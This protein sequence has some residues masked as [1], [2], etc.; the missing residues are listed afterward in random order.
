MKKKLALIAF[1]IVCTIGLTLSIASFTL[2]QNGSNATAETGNNLAEIYNS[3]LTQVQHIIE[4]SNLENTEDAITH[5]HIVQIVDTKDAVDSANKKLAD[6]IKDYINNDNDTAEATGIFRTDIIGSD[7]KNKHIDIETYVGSDSKLADAI[8]NADLVYIACNSTYTSS[9]DIKSDTVASDA[10]DALETYALSEFKPVI[11]DSDVVGVTNRDVEL[12]NSHSTKIYDYLKRISGL[13]ETVKGIGVVSVKDKDVQWD[14]FFDETSQQSIYVSFNNMGTNVANTYDYSNKNKAH[15]VLEIVPDEASKKGG[16]TDF[17]QQIDSGVFNKAFADDSTVT[18]DNIDYVSMTVTEFNAE[19]E[20]RIS[21]DGKTAKNSFFDY[22][23]IYIS[24]ESTDKL[25]FYEDDAAKGITKNDFSDNAI[26]A[27]KGFVNKKNTDREDLTEDEKKQIKESDYID[28]LIIDGRFFNIYSYAN[29]TS[30]NGKV[31]TSTKMY[32]FA[33]KLISKDATSTLLKNV[34]I[35]S[36]GYFGSMTEEKTEA[37]TS[38]INRSTYRTYA[39]GSN[40]ANFKVLEIQP[41]YSVDDTKWYNERRDDLTGTLANSSY[42]E[43]Y[44]ATNAMYADNVDGVTQSSPFYRFTMTQAKI[45]AATGLNMNQIVVT[46]MSANALC[47]TSPN[48]LEEYDLIYIGGNYSSIKDKK[49]WNSYK[50]LTN[51]KNASNGAAYSFISYHPDDIN[52]FYFGSTAGSN[53][54]SSLTYNAYVYPCYTHTGDFVDIT[55]QRNAFANRVGDRYENSGSRLNGNDITAKVYARLYEYISAGMPVVCD[56]EVIDSDYLIGGASAN[57]DLVADSDYKIDLETGGTLNRY[58]L[59]AATD[60]NA[61]LTFKNKSGSMQTITYKATNYSSSTMTARRESSIDPESYIYQ[62]MYQIAENKDSGIY[63]AKN[64]LVGFDSS[65]TTTTNNMYLQGVTSDIED[66]IPE[67]IETSTSDKKQNLVATLATEKY[68][69]YDMVTIF[70]NTRNGSK[71]DTDYA[72][73]GAGI[74]LKHFLNLYASSRPVINLIKAPENYDSTRDLDKK[75]RIVNP[76]SPTYTLSIN[77]E[78]GKTYE[79]RL[80]YDFDGDGKYSD[81]ATEGRLEG[82]EYEDEIVAKFDYTVGTTGNVILDENSSYVEKESFIIDSDFVGVMPYKLVVID[83]ENGKKT[84]IVGYPKYYSDTEE[85]K[86]TI[87]LLQIVPGYESGSMGNITQKVTTLCAHE[88]TLGNGSNLGSADNGKHEFGIVSA[89]DSTD[90]LAS[91]LFDEYNVDL[92]IMTT[93]QFSEMAELFILDYCQN[94]ET[95]KG[96]DKLSEDQIAD[97]EQFMADYYDSGSKKMKS[98]WTSLVDWNN[99]TIVDF[100]AL[101][102]SD[103]IFNSW[104]TNGDTEQEIK[105]NTKSYNGKTQTFS[106]GYYD[107]VVIGFSKEMGHN[108]FERA[109]I[110]NIGCQFLRAYIEDYGS[111]LLGTDTTSFEGF[112]DTSTM[113]WSRNINQYLRQAFGMD[114]F[115]FT[116]NGTKSTG[117]NTSDFYNYI[118]DGGTFDGGG[119]AYIYTPY[120]TVDYSDSTGQVYPGE[121]FT[122]NSYNGTYEQDTSKVN[123]M[124]GAG[125]TDAAD[126]ALS[127]SDTIFKGVTVANIGQGTAMLPTTSVARNNTGLITNYPFN[128]SAYP[129]ISKTNAQSYALDTEDDDMQIWYTLAGASDSDNSSLYAADPLNGRSYYYIYS[130]RNVTYTGAGYTAIAETAGN[131]EERKLIINAILSHVKIHRSGPKVVFSSYTGSEENDSV[132]TAATATQDAVLE[133]SAQTKNKCNFDFTVTTAKDRTFKDVTMFIDSNEDGIYNE[134]DGDILI[135]SYTESIENGVKVIVDGKNL[136]DSINAYMQGGSFV[137]T[138]SAKDSDDKTGSARLLVKTKSKLFNLN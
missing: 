108:V 74:Q 11:I 69:G 54:L 106:A 17:K 41:Y 25:Y 34:E 100:N 9:N 35:T 103:T 85:N 56:K 50:I 10:V 75:T 125:A 96:R 15:K 128:I 72:N 99:T 63:H 76:K 59:D 2:G 12:D 118:N 49:E 19:V 58:K 27:L 89:S 129:R 115:K 46:T 116:T 30:S 7:M 124:A 37:I 137:I 70:N 134:D 130:Y 31:D 33:T 113:K 57:A 39:G 53:K 22:E 47:S 136:P 5:Y 43:I 138:V 29:S 104:L 133:C 92:T 80:Y 8:R 112:F 24:H 87:R 32:E 82:T 86:Q 111:V 51:S 84:S 1:T 77:G 119:T 78:H 28:R 83:K 55:D 79:V 4:N 6:Y 94:F 68:S 42:Q 126:Y 123:A 107:M 52:L 127:G 62:L 26:S 114:R 66:T 101:G 20:R 23:F 90:N 45:A 91:R 40:G 71:T 14:Q 121:Y 38:L 110:N 48:L 3:Y 36:S 65:D 18:S 13:S 117:S 132:F 73:S 64:V 93:G 98:T 135:K 102:I 16:A 95:Y 109:D 88:N 61:T 105:L 67:D 97:F 21:E 81:D 122:T 131:D 44:E 60:P 120:K